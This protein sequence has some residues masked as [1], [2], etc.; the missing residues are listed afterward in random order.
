MM[1]PYS[2]RIST[3]C[4][5]RGGYRLMKP[6]MLI[7]ALSVLTAGFAGAQT[8]V[9]GDIAGHMV[10]ATGAAVVNA[11]LTLK[12]LGDGSSQTVKTDKSGNYRFP[13]LR[14]G[15]YSIHAQG[16]G[17]SADVKSV[18]VNVGQGT[19]VDLIAKP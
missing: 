12:N 16:S 5:F 3:V 19:P 7:L 1:K 17:L 9:T 10:D 18:A 2:L 8:L 4:L 15:L 14:P 6:L 11:T 13:L